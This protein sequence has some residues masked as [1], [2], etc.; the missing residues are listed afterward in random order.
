MKFCDQ[1]RDVQTEAQV[2]RAAGALA[3][4]GHHRIE[5][6][7]SDRIGQGWTLI[8]NPEND[9]ALLRN[10][11]DA[12]RGSG[13][14]KVHRVFRE[15]VEHLREQVGRALREHGFIRHR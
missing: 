6:R 9:S 14:R 13:G 10:Q 15:L 2:R 12:H 4:Q 3:A 8:F 5:Q 1:T 11:Q 7:F